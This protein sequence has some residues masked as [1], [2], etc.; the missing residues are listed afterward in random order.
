MYF[1]KLI[2]EAFGSHIKKTIEFTPG[3][4]VIIG[5]SEKGKTTL[6]RAMYL[7]IENSP[8]AGE[9]LYQSDLTEN[10][11]SV[12][13][14]NDQGNSVKRLKNKYYL[15]DGKPLKA[16]GTGVPEPIKEFFNFKE[17]NWQ[18]Q[19]DVH[20][21]IFS[22]GGA[23]A[24]LLNSATGMGDQ[25]VIINQ[26]KVNLSASKSEVKRIKKNNIEHQQTLERLKNIVRYRLK[27]EAILYLN[28]ETIEIEKQT[29]RLENI[30]NQLEEIKEIK[31]QC[32]KGEKYMKDLN[33]IMENQKEVENFKTHITKLYSLL[34]KVEGI[35]TFD[36]D[37]LKGYV[38]SLQTLERLN[39]E[40]ITTIKA[41]ESIKKF[42]KDIEEQ[43]EIQIKHLKDI[44]LY[45]K[46]IEEAFISLGYCPLCQREIKDGD[47]CCSR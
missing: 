10:D 22:T 38:K 1:T 36:H 15:N 5:E 46:E 3:L 39:L 42:I 31:S 6:I 21:I 27:A 32:A 18:K 20:Y 44:E 25:E 7:L 40:Y 29:N 33:R 9:K 13:L 35:D 11:L 12:E 30:L 26:I 8:R 34:T 43:R 2:V 45:E 23:A 4:N 47:T 16:F 28:E 41:S 14:I 24:R 17:I 19:M 37:M